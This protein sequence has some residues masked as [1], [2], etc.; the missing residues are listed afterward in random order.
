[1]AIW[2]PTS[3]NEHSSRIY[4]ATPPR[5]CEERSD[6]AIWFPKST[7]APPMRS[8]SYCSNPLYKSTHPGFMDATS[9]SLR[10]RFHPLICFSRL[11]AASTLPCDS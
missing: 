4:A 7:Q 1:M 6:V 2:P 3:R 8:L 9:A 10:L 5:H 11:I